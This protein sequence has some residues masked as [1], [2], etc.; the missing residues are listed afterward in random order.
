MLLAP[1]L[2]GLDLR[3]A[4]IAILHGV[5]LLRAAGLTPRRR[6]V[7]SRGT[8]DLAH[9]VALLGTRG[10]PANY[11]GFETFAERLAL[12][13]TADDIRTT[14]YCRSHYATEGSEWRGIRLVTLPTIRSKYFDT[15][16][17]TLLSALH[18]VLTSRCR[19]VVLC[20][21][22]NAPVLLVLRMFGAGCCSTSTGS[23]GDAAS[24]VSPV[25]RGTAWGSGSRSGSPRC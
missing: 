15:V 1:G 23:N 6:A 5:P 19:D 16:V 10:I 20:N 25:G 3:V 12:H 7:R 2:G 8:R 18:L 22:A 9:G 4:S 11:G 24:G 17:H 13:L 21:A 14:V